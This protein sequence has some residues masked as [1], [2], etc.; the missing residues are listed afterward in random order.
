MAVVSSMFNTMETSGIEMVLD[1]VWGKNTLINIRSGKAIP[2]AIRAIHLLEA[3]LTFKLLEKVELLAPLS[4]GAS[5]DQ[6]VQCR[7][8]EASFD[9]IKKQLMFTVGLLLFLKTRNV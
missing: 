4:D 6:T 9:N 3:G 8:L 1:E 5:I 7:I 2:R